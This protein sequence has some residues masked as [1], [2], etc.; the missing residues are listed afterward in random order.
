MENNNDKNSTIPWI[1]PVAIV[2]M[3]IWGIVGLF[4]GDGFFGGIGK[5]IDAIGKIVAWAIKGGLVVGGI[6]LI[7]QY[8]NKREERKREKRVP[9]SELKALNFFESD[10]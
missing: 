5:Q 10:Y 4:E 7:G 9:E 6:W 8:F 1:V 2:L 3:V